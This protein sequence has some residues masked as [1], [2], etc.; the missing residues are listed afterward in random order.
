MYL[1]NVTIRVFHAFLILLLIGAFSACKSDKSKEKGK[2]VSL[3]DFISGEDIFDDIDKAKK[4]FYSLPSPLETAMLIK[5][6]GADYNE[7]L[8]NSLSNVDK[9][10]TNKS[11]ALNLGIYTTDLSFCSLFDQ[12]QTS[13]N[14][15]DATRKLA[16]A[17]DIKDAIDQE[18]L[19]RLEE[20]L[21][22]RDVV[23][24]IISETFLNSS[25]YLKENE[26]QAV[27]AIVLVG[28]WVEGLYLA[29]QLVGEQSLEGNKLVDRIAEQK[30]SFS[31]VDR[32]LEDNK[33]NE[34]GEQNADIV[35]L[36]NEL[37]AL[38]SAYSKI[39]VQTSAVKVEPDQESNVT[40]LKSQTKITVTPEAFN[41]LREAVDALRTNFIL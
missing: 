27:A 30:L 34:R 10:T 26:R 9:Y 19:T 25:S 40:T 29:T 2:E 4:I 36:M 15:M 12:T 11:M 35:E 6:A 32:M 20:N 14:Y 41:E 33:V 5:S 31:I 8:L 38:R 21:N 1:K 24:D 16:E 28:G 13:L 39:I 3:D 23:M 37:Q 22:N 17:M 7:Q 18:T